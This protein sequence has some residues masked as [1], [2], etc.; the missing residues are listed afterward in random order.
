[1]KK[2]HKKKIK[3]KKPPKLL[4]KKRKLINYKNHSLVYN[5]LGKLLKNKN[6]NL[7]INSVNEYIKI[8]KNI[9]EGD[10]IGTFPNGDILT[11][12]ND[13]NHLFLLKYKIYSNKLFKLKLNFTEQ[14]SG[15][16]FLIGNN[17]GGYFNI[18]YIKIYLFSENNTT[19]K[20][21]QRIMFP[22]NFPH[23]IIF[24]FSFINNNNLYFFLKCFSY[25][26]GKITLYKLNENQIKNDNNE[27]ITEKKFEEN[28]T[29]SIDFPFI[30]FAQK[31]NNELIFFMEED[32][33]FNLIVY[34][35]EE[36]KVINHKKINL[37]KIDNPRCANYVNKVLYEKYLIYT[38]EN[39]MF[40][41]NLDQME[42][43][44]IKELNIIQFIHISDDNTIW[45]VEYENKYKYLNRKKNQYN[46]LK[47]YLLDI[48][49]LELLKIGERPMTNRIVKNIRTLINNKILL[50]VEERKV[51]LFSSKN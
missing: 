2:I 43:E 23:D 24:P 9:I 32:N 19:Y 14:R 8:N 26:K 27:I 51:E 21:I 30:W 47:Q 22:V 6:I 50:F 48:N 44:T 3:A 15:R 38:N 45:T 34:N 33:I 37:V 7:N 17:Y 29:I 12:S 40:I 46:Y 36:K 42:I 13:Q 10:F 41:I 1:M 25:E 4:G 20:I 35:F 49:C 18:S 39:L 11:E 5:T 31:N 28:E 16:F